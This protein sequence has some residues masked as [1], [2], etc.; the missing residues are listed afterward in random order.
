LKRFPV[1]FP[2]YTD[3]DLKISA[4]IRAVA[5]FPSTVFYDRAGEIA[6]VKQGGYATERQLA[7]DIE[8]Y[9]R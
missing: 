5:A 6:H 1:P 3:K 9:A 7:E 4:E 8:R 2:S